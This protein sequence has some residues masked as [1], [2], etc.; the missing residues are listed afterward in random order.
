[1]LV[2]KFIAMLNY[3]KTVGI[4]MLY[5]PQS[6]GEQGNLAAQNEL[7][8]N[9]NNRQEKF[10]PSSGLPATFRLLMGKT[11][12]SVHCFGSHSIILSIH[13]KLIP[14]F[15]KCKIKKTGYLETIS[16]FTGKTFNCLL[17]SVS[18]KSK[19]LV[20]IF[21]NFKLKSLKAIR[22]PRYF[23]SLTSEL[24]LEEV[25]KVC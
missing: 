25:K 16:V 18:L 9:D 5:L 8:Y 19:Y 21:L 2:I 3:P 11:L 15:H 17:V 13:Y 22:V 1:M 23:S 10:R 24:V 4:R 20:Q 12:L 7:F 14:Q 6:L